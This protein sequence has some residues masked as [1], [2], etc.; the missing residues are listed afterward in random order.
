M[1]EVST[2]QQ[3]FD[4]LVG[5]AFAKQCAFADTVP[6]HWSMWRWS[7]EDTR[8]LVN[9]P[10]LG[11]FEAQYLGTEYYATNTWVHA[12]ADESLNLLGRKAS[13]AFK[14][15]YINQPVTYAL[16]D[17]KRPLTEVN[18]D[19]IGVLATQLLGA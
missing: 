14:Q 3:L 7:T 5:L 4:S 12:W 13:N 11:T 15:H 10:S 19:Y 18:G 9:L 2:A 1:K 16:T 8:Y 17:P 6:D